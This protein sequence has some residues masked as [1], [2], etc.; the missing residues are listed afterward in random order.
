MESSLGGSRIRNMGSKVLKQKLY[1]YEA[2]LKHRDNR[3]RELQ[4]ALNGRDLQIKQL[5]EMA[6][7]KGLK[8]ENFQSS[9]G[10]HPEERAAEPGVDDNENLIQAKSEEI[11]SLRLVVN[12]KQQEIERLSSAIEHERHEWELKINDQKVQMDGIIAEKDVRLK[13]LEGL[14]RNRESELERHTTKDNYFKKQIEAK[15]KLLKIARSAAN[16][17]GKELDLLRKRIENKEQEL[18]FIT[19]ELKI[20]MSGLL[21]EKDD[22]IRR[23]EG[24]LKVKEGELERKYGEEKE[25]HKQM[26][27]KEEEITTIRA[28]MNQKEQE[29]LELTNALENKEQ[30]LRRIK[31]EMSSALPA[32]KR[33]LVV[34]KGRNF[35]EALKAFFRVH[36]VEHH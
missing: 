13:A 21:T 6:R 26:Q 10:D 19:E 3:I 11:N 12:E 20:E 1:E 23:L 17:K 31:S 8:I 29:V 15:E 18:D 22:L 25:S 9:T 36:R 27:V 14:L 34:I 5:L 2:T 35:W 30:E 32:T 4:E 33:R 24:S 28:A 16:E 7:E